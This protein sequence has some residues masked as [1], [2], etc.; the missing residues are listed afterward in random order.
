[1]SYLFLQVLLR[2]RGPVQKGFFS[3]G[4]APPHVAD[5]GDLGVVEGLGQDEVRSVYVELQEPVAVLDEFF[6]DQVPAFGRLY[7]LVLEG[8][9]QTDQHFRVVVLERLGYAQRF[10][11]E[12]ELALE[13]VEVSQRDGSQAACAGRSGQSEHVFTSCDSVNF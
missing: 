3:L 2:P 11:L 4:E 6:N 9:A 7:L 8:L 5:D 12:L 13:E 10:A 1:M